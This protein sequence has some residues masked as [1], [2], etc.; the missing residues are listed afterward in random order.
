MYKERFAENLKR[1][2]DS[3]GVTKA[4]R[5]IG[6]RQQTLSRYLSAQC[7][8]TIENLVKIANYY[9]EDLDVLTGRK[10]Y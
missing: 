1:L 7:E 8:I 3:D 5:N 9:N 4:A 6:I 10:E 2:I